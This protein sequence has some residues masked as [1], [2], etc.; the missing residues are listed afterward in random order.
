[1]AEPRIVSKRVLVLTINL[2]GSHFKNIDIVLAKS[3]VMYVYLAPKIY[4]LLISF[5]P[6]IQYIL[7]P[8]YKSTA[9]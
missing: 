7:Y 6:A 8:G 4:R 9:R 2:L 5:I 1:M 3:I